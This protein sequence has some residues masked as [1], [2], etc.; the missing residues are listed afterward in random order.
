MK[1]RIAKKIAG[2]KCF[3]H[4]VARPQ[5][6]ARACKRLR[7]HPGEKRWLDAITLLWKARQA[8]KEWTSP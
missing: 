5:T 7:K 8:M 1:L 6:F 3:K 4:P 2:P